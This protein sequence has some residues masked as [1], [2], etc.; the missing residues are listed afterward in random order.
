MFKLDLIGPLSLNS[1]NMPILIGI[2]LFFYLTLANKELSSYISRQDFADLVTTTAIVGIICARILYIITEQPDMSFTGWLKLWEGGLSVLGAVVSSVLYVMA[3]CLY[4]NINVIKVLDISLVYVPIIHAFGRIGC[5]LTGCCFG[6]YTNLFNFAGLDRHP[7]QLY[8]SAIFLIIF[9][10]L[11]YFCK[12]VKMNGFIIFS[13]LIL[14][15]AERIMVDFFRADRTYIWG[16][17]LFSANQII[18]IGI[19][20][21][22]VVCMFFYNNFYK[23]SYDRYF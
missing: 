7:S 3:F 2:L 16:I 1:Y 14:A 21:V 8:S 5:F 23:L 12:S 15:S 10:G 11:N 13:Y 17:E 22:A 4:K 19:I 6:T 20:L 9:L 18:A